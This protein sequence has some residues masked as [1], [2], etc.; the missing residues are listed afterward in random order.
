[1]F[2]EGQWRGRVELLCHRDLHGKNEG[3]PRAVGLILE[4]RLGLELGLHVHP[5]TGLAAL[6]VGGIL[7][8][9]IELGSRVAETKYPHKLL[10]LV[11]RDCLVLGR[12]MW[13]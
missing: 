4:D 3:R 1:M 5:D 12:Q 9:E 10:G 7:G 8:L 6:W 11:V 2:T 13:R